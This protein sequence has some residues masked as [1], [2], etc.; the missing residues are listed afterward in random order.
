VVELI[1]H[2]RFY[3]SFGGFLGLVMLFYLLSIIAALIHSWVKTPKQD[4]GPS[5]LG[6]VLLGMGIGFSGILLWAVDFLV[7][8]GFDIPGTNWAPVLFAVAP[9]G[10]ALGV[11]RGSQ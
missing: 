3:H 9:I 4:V 6:W 7:L 8:S 2:P 11:K 1:F 10:M 5:G